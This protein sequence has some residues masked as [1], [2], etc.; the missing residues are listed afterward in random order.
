MLY[1]FIVDPMLNQNKIE[2]EN[3]NYIEHDTWDGF[4]FKN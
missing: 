2:H 1:H 3:Q 4:N